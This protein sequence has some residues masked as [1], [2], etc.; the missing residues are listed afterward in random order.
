MVPKQSKYSE[1]IRFMILMPFGDHY[2]I[3]E[4]SY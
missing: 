2:L 4:N 1:A 3:E